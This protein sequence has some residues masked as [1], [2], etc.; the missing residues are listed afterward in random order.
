MVEF[1]EKM[2]KNFEI[3]LF[4]SDTELFTNTLV[5][6]MIKYANVYKTSQFSHG[7]ENKFSNNIS[8]VLSKLQCSSNEFGHDIKNL[9]LFVGEGSRRKLQN[10]IIVDSSIFSF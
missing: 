5:K 6:K 3:V 2:A 1:I 7:Q 9:D 8:H 10:C 4:N